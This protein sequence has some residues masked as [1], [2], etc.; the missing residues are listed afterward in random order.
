MSNI[1]TAASELLNGKMMFKGTAGENPP[2]VTDYIPPM[3]DGKGYMPL[4]LFLISLSSCLGG[5][6]V[7]SSAQDRQDDRRS[8]GRRERRAARAAPN[9]LRKDNAACLR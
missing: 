3:G 6:A 9:E 4:E 2:I 5:G 8:Y 7:R 1:V